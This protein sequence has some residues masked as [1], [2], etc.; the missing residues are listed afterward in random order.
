MSG[1]PKA[2][3]RRLDF[4]SSIIYNFNVVLLNPCLLSI[5]K[6]LYKSCGRLMISLKTL[7]NPIKIKL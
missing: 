7:N 1:P 2:I 4:I 6:V 5:T 3:K